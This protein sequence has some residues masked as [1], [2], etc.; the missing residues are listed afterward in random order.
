MK[1]YLEMVQGKLSYSRAQ[2]ARWQETFAEDPAHALSWGTGAF[3][4]AAVVRV[5]G[6]VATAL[7]NNMEANGGD[8]QGT[9]VDGFKAHAMER[10]MRVAANP[11]QSTSPTSNLFE[12]YEAKAWTSVY[13]LLNGESFY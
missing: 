12:Q 7:S 3:E 8:L 6:Q 5:F 9:F 13:K 4:H 1:N 10:F 2:V 11:P